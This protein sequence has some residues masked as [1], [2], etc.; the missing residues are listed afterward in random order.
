MSTH[1]ASLSTAH[2]RADFCICSCSF[3]TVAKGLHIVG[4]FV[5]NRQDAIEALDYVARGAVK[6]MVAVEPL[7]NVESIYERLEKGQIGGRVVVSCCTK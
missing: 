7:A 2:V 1:P 4:S 5:G 6:P 3:W